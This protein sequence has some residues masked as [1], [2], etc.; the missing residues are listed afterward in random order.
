MIAVSKNLEREMSEKN[1]VGNQ[2]MDIGFDL[3]TKNSKP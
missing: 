2:S 1:S 3:Y